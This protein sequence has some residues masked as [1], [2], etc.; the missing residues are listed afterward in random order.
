MEQQETTEQQIQRIKNVLLRVKS[1]I[2]G[3]TFVIKIREDDKYGN[4]IYLQYYYRSKCNQTGADVMW[5]GR[6]WY[7]SEH[8]LDD[9]IVKTAYAAFK[10]VVEHEM[11]EGFK[12]DGIIL[13]NP[14]INF[15]ELLKISHKEITRAAHEKVNTQI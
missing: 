13:F 2:F 3:Q 7:L 1:T 15:E 8:M 12:V 4:R 5:Y 9:E 6:K 10:A 14:H 11:M